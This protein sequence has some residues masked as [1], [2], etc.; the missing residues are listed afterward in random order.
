MFFRPFLPFPGR[1]WLCLASRPS[2]PSLQPSVSWGLVRWTA[3]R[4]K[5]RAARRERLRDE[6]ARAGVQAVLAAAT[7]L[8]LEP[9]AVQAAAAHPSGFLVQEAAPSACANPEC[10]P[11]QVDAPTQ[12]GQ[13][14]YLSI[15]NAALKK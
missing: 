9:T 5:A 7:A 15:Q 14:V 4:G 13:D 6:I 8:R 10:R 1:L 3:V 11:A 12:T 2:S